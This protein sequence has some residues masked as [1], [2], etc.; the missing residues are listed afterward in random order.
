MIYHACG[1]HTQPMATA[2]I[3]AADRKAAAQRRQAREAEERR[4]RAQ[5]AQDERDRDLR[6]RVKSAH[7]RGEVYPLVL[8]PG[9]PGF[10]RE[11]IQAEIIEGR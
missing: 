7:E 4:A 5:R 10:L 3:D 6:E 11:Q 1:L 9:I 2:L 8:P